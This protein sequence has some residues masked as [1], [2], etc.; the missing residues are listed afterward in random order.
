[1]G[2]APEV[3]SAVGDLTIQVEDPSTY[4]S[5]ATLTAAE[6]TSD[7]IH[8]HVVLATKFSFHP[9]QESRKAKGSHL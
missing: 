6:W 9:R 8:L 3:P 2:V 4:L 5:G 1:M 7:G